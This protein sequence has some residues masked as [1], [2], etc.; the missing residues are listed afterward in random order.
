L[1]LEV[2]NGDNA[3]LEID[4][5]SAW[6]PVVR[7]LF[8]AADTQPVTLRFGDRSLPAPAYDVGLVA[9]ELL[10]ADAAEA[11]FSDRPGRAG[12]RR[13]R[14]PEGRPGTRSG[15]PWAPWSSRSSR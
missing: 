10:N 14:R 13:S 9:T 7:L 4:Q 3:P 12:Q 1:I 6:Y 8:R 11:R 15:S 5:V 2:D